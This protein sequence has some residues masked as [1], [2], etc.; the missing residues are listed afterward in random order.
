[1][2]FIRTPLFFGVFIVMAV[3]EI[4]WNF[5]LQWG[6]YGFQNMLVSVYI[7]IISYRKKKR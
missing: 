3:L 6:S 5:S 7:E 4:F 1:M 2:G